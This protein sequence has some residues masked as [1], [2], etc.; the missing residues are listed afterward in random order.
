MF[1]SIEVRTIYL[2]DVSYSVQR[3]GTM[4]SYMYG[5]RKY[6]SLYGT[7]HLWSL[8]SIPC[9]LLEHILH[10]H[11]MDHLDRHHVLTDNQHGFRRGRSC[12]TQLAG[13]VDDLAQI[14]DRKSQAGLVILDFSK[15]FDTVPH[16]WLLKNLEH[17]GVN[18]NLLQWIGNFLTKR[19]QKVLLQGETSTQSPVT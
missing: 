17:V 15:A 11:I 13:L 2:S 7:A 6:G 10:H 12:E 19:R 5:V 3:T 18:N 14:L 4:P 16:Q 9:K 8:T 1:R